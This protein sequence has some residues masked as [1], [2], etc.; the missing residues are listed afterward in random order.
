V[1]VVDTNVLLYA[2]DNSSPTHHHCAGMLDT[3]R[4]STAPWHVT[5]SILY[6][7]LRVAT[8]PRVFRSPWTAT[9]GITFIQG[10][11]AAPGLS[12]LTPT[13]RHGETLAGVVAEVPGLNGNILHDVHTV[14]LMREHGVR[15][16]HTADADF[17]RFQHLQVIDPN[18]GLPG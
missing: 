8:H 10:L 6:E 15:T 2:A 11:L 13:E 14:T 12:V 5:W 3:W 16:I 1:F 4:R 17:L 18:T 9:S 7:F